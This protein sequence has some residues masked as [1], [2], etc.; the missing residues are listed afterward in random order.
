MEARLARR[1]SFD[2]IIPDKEVV[3]VHRTTAHA[4]CIRRE[5]IVVQF[6]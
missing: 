5:C 6:A 1:E 4:S 2:A 3:V